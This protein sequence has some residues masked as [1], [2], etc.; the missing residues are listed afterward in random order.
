MARR[1]RMRWCIG[2]LGL[3]ALACRPDAA[4]RC[5]EE[6]GRWVESVESG[7]GVCAHHATDEGTSCEGAGQCQ[8]DCVAD[9]R[10]PTATRTRGVCSAWTSNLGQCLNLVEDGRAQGMLCLQ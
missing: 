4:E 8:G 9:A 10:V 5:R 3:L 6:G 7:A 1:G 2:V